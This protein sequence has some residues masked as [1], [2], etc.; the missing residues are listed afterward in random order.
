MSKC[1]VDTECVGFILSTNNINC[2]LY[3]PNEPKLLKSNDDT[4][5]Y[6]NCKNILYPD[7]ITKK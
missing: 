7:D 4:L 2:M 5:S 3:G 1:L 6:Y